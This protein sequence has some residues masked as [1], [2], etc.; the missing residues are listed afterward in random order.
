MVALSACNGGAA[1][2]PARTARVSEVVNVVEARQ[3]EQSAFAPALVG[4]TVKTQ[5]QV[6]TGTVSKARVDFSEGSIVRLSDNTL[7]TVEATTVTDGDLVSRFQLE[8]G[9]VWISVFNHKLELQTPAGI[10][11]VRGSFAVAEVILENPNDP[12]SAVLLFDC[13]EGACTA[14]NDF[15]DTRFGNLERVV[16]RKDQRQ[17]APEAAPPERLREF[18][19]NNR[20]PESQRIIPTLTAAPTRTP[21]FALPRPS[22]RTATPE[23]TRATETRVLDPRISETPTISRTID[24]RPVTVDPRVTATSTPL[25]RDLTPIIERTPIVDSRPPTVA[26]RPTDPPPIIRAT[27]P[28]PIIRATDPPPIIRATDPPPVIRPPDPPRNNVT[29]VPTRR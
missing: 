17:V 19:D 7:L 6:R 25:L 12:Q 13:L 18:L 22:E 28:P 11:T 1:G 5:G 9:K 23:E 27:D 4:L 16:L 29:P 3:P 10:A 15:V 21:I 24:I 14:K 8:L 2:V 20:N 26:S